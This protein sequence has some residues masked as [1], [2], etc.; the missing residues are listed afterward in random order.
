M[1]DHHQAKPRLLS[2]VNRFPAESETFIERKAIALAR[3]GFDVTVAASHVG[4]SSG[5]GSGSSPGT[6]TETVSQLQLPVARDPRTW[7]PTLALLGGAA[8]RRRASPLLAT[9]R[10]GHWLVSIAAGG[11]DIVHFE[12]SGIAAS[13]AELLPLLRPAR[14]V[15]SC[16]GAAEQITPHRDPAR[17][18]RLERVFAEVDLIHCVSDDMAEIVR[19]FGAPDEKILV[20]RP[21]VDVARWAG[22]GQVDPAPRGSADAPLRIL[23]VGRLHWKKAFDDAVRA[24]ATAKAQG[25][26]I[27]YRIAGDGP[28][29]EKLLYLRNSLGLDDEVTFLGWQSQQEIEQQMAWA[30][31]F[32]LPS[33]SEGIS[34]SA[35]EAMAAGVPLVATRCGGMAEAIVYPDDGILVDIGDV[36]AMASALGTLCSPTR[37]GELASGEHAR[38]EAEFDL[39]RQVTV[40]EAAYRAL[41]D[42][43]ERGPS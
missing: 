15:V 24:M 8:P 25:L 18:G 37:R 22:V 41:L 31:G 35:L 38:V 39:S 2:V 13:V 5:S 16:R 19:G 20:N 9:P 33:L 10:R 36:E 29:L 32:L 28:E 23:S 34:N 21:A 42:S 26:H 12:F 4:R 17:A 14:L 7:W 6:A 30:D 1:S 43:Q 40:F 27:R 3:A 11:Y